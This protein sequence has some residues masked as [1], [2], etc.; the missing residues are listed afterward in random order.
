MRVNPRG[1][2]NLAG[3][4]A[5]NPLCFLAAGK[6]GPSDDQGSHARVK[7]PLNHRLAIGMKGP[8]RKIKAARKNNLSNYLA[9]WM[10]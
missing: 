4:L 2:I 10:K 7:R 3:I 1:G 6:T 8:M 9:G 5:C